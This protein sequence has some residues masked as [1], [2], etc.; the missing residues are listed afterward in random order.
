MPGGWTVMERTTGRR[1]RCRYAAL[2]DV[3]TGPSPLPVRTAR[4]W[5]YRAF[6]LAMAEPSDAEYGADHALQVS[7]GVSVL[8]LRVEISIFESFGTEPRHRIDPHVA[9]ICASCAADS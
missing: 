9:S 6:G 3:S 8:P 1:L 4:H 7:S 5:R 2:I